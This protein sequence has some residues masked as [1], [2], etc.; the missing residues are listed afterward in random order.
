[1]RI[2]RR[3]LT[4][5]NYNT[6][7]SH[8][9]KKKKLIDKCNISLICYLYMGFRILKYYLVSTYMAFCCPTFYIFI[10]F[11]SLVVLKYY[12]IYIYIYIYIY[13]IIQLILI[14]IYSGVAK[15]CLGWAIAQSRF[16]FFFYLYFFYKKKLP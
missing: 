15:A 10:F 8:K 14:Y 11:G 16:F 6:T 12:S 3:I 13:I 2:I 4:M 5:K 9:L 7:Y 1:M